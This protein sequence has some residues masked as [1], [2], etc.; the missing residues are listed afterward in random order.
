M[1]IELSAPMVPGK[2]LFT[3]E[4]FST[5]KKNYS[6]QDITQIQTVTDASPLINGVFLIGLKN[7]KPVQVAYGNGKKSDGHFVLSFLKGKIAE[8]GSE[9]DTLQDPDLDTAEKLYEY[10]VNNGF[11]TGFTKG[12]ALSHFQIIIDNLLPGEKIL[13]PFIGLHNFVSMSQH[14]NNFAYAVT[15]KRII[16]AQKKVIGQVMQTVNWENINDITM[17][18]GVA[19]G[20]ITIDSYKETFNVG[21]GK[22]FA[23]NINQRL[24]EVYQRIKHPVTQTTEPHASEPQPQLDSY[25]ELKKVKELYDAGILTEEE[26]AAKKKQLLGL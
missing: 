9:V 15:D 16:M 26:F 22:T 24:Q 25:E 12:W 20:V 6:Y 23:G 8:N 14:D 17:S 1:N 3:D 5:G 21:V 18:T 4:G 10:C 13:F 19:F 2:T 7:D 11:G